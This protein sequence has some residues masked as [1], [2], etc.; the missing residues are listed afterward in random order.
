MSLERCSTPHQPQL[1][2]CRCRAEVGEGVVRA[3]LAA[4][5]KGLAHPELIEAARQSAEHAFK[6]TYRYAAVDER[7]E[8]V[9]E[10]C[11]MTACQFELH[12][13]PAAA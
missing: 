12:A 4:A 13:C 9:R 10:A 7:I 1:S 2:A 11:E 8:E 5:D 6:Q 3:D